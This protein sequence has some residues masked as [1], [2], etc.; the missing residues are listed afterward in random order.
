[1]IEVEMSI[2]TAITILQAVQSYLD[3]KQKYLPTPDPKEQAGIIVAIKE[4]I[5]QLQAVK[6]QLVEQIRLNTTGP[7]VA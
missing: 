5:A 1:M 3:I 7:N 2:P 4:E 6:C